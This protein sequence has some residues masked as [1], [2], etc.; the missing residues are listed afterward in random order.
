M[1]HSNSPRF[2]SAVP[3]LRSSLTVKQEL[4]PEES[5]IIAEAHYMLSLALE[6]ASIKPVAEDGDNSDQQVCKF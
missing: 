6:F 1:T 4:Y 5:E 2:A 3:D